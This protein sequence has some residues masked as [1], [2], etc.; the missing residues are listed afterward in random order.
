[1][2]S[3]LEFSFDTQFKRLATDLPEPVHEFQFDPNRK[4]R[5]DRAWVEQ[6]V[7]VEIEG[8]SYPTMI[9]CHNCGQIVR[10]RTKSGEV[11]RQIRMAGAHG[12]SGYAKDI[13]KYNALASQ[14]WLLLRFAHDDIIGKPFE[15]VETIS[16]ALD[17]R[18]YV[19][20]D[21]EYLGPSE[22][23][24][25]YL[26]AAGFSSGEVADRLGKKQTTIRRKVQA[27]CEKLVVRTRAAAVARAMMWK[28][29]NPE[30]IPFPDTEPLPF[31]N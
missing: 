27:V 15:M 18:G 10:A 6:K 13:E 25:L 9:R 4:W 3:E 30:Q 11:G 12:G 1:M 22:R 16:K 31:E 8:G 28:L 5:L 19:K 14:G 2:K 24:V 20:R 17:M 7:A 21:I 23:E 26:I 29:L